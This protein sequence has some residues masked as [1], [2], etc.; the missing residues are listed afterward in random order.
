MA[1]TVRSPGKASNVA[2]I[3]QHPEDVLCGIVI[4]TTH[5]LKT[6]QSLGLSLHITVF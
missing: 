2:S 4:Q 5:R 3:R 6:Q 1:L